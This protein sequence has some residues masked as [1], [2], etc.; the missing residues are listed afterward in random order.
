[1]QRV[2]SELSLLAQ[3]NFCDGLCVLRYRDVRKRRWRCIFQFGRDILARP[4]WCQTVKF[5]MNKKMVNRETVRL[6]EITAT[7]RCQFGWFSVGV[8]L[9]GCAIM[10][11]HQ[12]SYWV[13]G[14]EVYIVDL[15][16]V[17]WLC[18][19]YVC[20]FKSCEY[21]RVVWHV[22]RWVV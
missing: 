22:R 14:G 3:I 12:M 7:L 9:G 1:M 15:S 5:G 11:Q 6:Q 20:N 17:C 18:S 19:F 8:K 10:Y 16:D 2:T 21:R 13:F 4:T